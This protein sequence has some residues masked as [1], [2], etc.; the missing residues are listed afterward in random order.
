MV[1][2]GLDA[3]GVPGEVF[4]VPLAGR[5]KPYEVHGAA[6]VV[7]TVEPGPEKRTEVIRTVGAVWLLRRE[8]NRALTITD[9]ASG[10]LVAQLDKKRRDGA[11]GQWPVRLERGTVT[12]APKRWLGADGAVLLETRVEGVFRRSVEVT[13]APSGLAG[14][15][16][17]LLAVL[18]RHVVLDTDGDS[19]AVVFTMT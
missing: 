13:V 10:G 11:V 14:W 4:A 16:V 12:G 19:A 2:V 6:G 18:T 8:R 7:A 9:T 3:A 1:L 15:A 17:V 5:N